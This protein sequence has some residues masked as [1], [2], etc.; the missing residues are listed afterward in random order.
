MRRQI[1]QELFCKDRQTDRI[2]LLDHHVRK[3]RGKIGGVLDL[4]NVPR[5]CVLHR[6]TRIH[7]DV[8][9]E[10]R[11]LF[12]LLDVVAIGLTVNL[13][14]NVFDLITGHVLPMLSELDA[15][16]VIGTLVQACDEAFDDESCPKL[17]IRE[18]R[19]NGRLKI[20]AV[21]VAQFFFVVFAAGVFCAVTGRS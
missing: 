14:V 17:H 16:A 15:E 10:I 18:P 4:P 19:H 13:P 6:A 1:G 8:R 3:R 11:L 9:F 2:L 7:H 12:V 5:R 20:L 21:I